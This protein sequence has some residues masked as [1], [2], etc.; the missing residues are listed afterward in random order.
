MKLSKKTEIIQIVCRGVNIHTHTQIAIKMFWIWGLTASSV[1][2]GALYR[3]KYP[4]IVI[5][6]R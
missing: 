6:T 5:T 1:E 2:A 4:I 3:V